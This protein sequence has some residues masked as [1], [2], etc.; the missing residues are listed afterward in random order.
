VSGTQCTG[1]RT[2]LTP[3]SFTE[4]ATQCIETLEEELREVEE[5]SLVILDNFDFY[6]EDDP[7]GIKINAKS[8][9]DIETSLAKKVSS[10][11]YFLSD[12]LERNKLGAICN[13]YEYLESQM[14]DED[15]ENRPDWVKT[16]ECEYSK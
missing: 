1:D 2:S 12:D 7:F 4:H 8:F 3:F 13:F 15:Y 5:E 10:D 14:S 11:G 16:R 9:E 6:L